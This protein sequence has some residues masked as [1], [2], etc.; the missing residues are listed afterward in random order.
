MERKEDEGRRGKKEVERG[1]R[2]RME[3]MENLLYHFYR[4]WTPCTAS[5]NIL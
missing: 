4:G 1:V 3:N 2:N 5:D